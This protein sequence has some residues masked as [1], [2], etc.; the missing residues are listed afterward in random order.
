[1]MQHG[2]PIES[3]F[4]FRSVHV[5]SVLKSVGGVRRGMKHLGQEWEMKAQKPF[6]GNYPQQNA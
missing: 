1:M 2:Q 5:L 3:I 6:V 4:S